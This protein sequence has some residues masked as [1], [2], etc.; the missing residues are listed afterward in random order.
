VFFVAASAL[1][2]LTAAPAA[3]DDAFQAFWSAPDPQAAGKAADAIVK[4]GVGFDEAY[5]RLKQGRKYSTDVPRGVVRLSHHFAQGEF[6]YTIEVPQTYD[7]A[8]AYQVRV[9]LHGGVMGREDGTIRGA[10]AIGALAGAEQ[11]YVLPTSWRDAPWWNDVQIENLDAILDSLRRAYNVDENRTVLAGVSDG[12]TANYYFAMRDTTPFASFNTLN[13]AMAVLQSPELAIKV[14]L[15]PQNLVNKPFFIVNGGRDPLY[16]TSFVEPYIDHLKQNGVELVYHPQPTGV[17]NTAWWP[18]EKDAFETFVREHPRRPVPDRLSWETDLSG[19]SNRA[20]WLVIDKLMEKDDPRE[21]L[22]DAN[23][24]VERA[25]GEFGARVEGMQIKGVRS[26]SDADFFGLKAGDVVVSIN[27]KTR[28]ATGDFLDWLDTFEPRTELTIGVTRS[29]EALDLKALFLPIEPLPPL[30]LF[31]FRRQAGRVDLLREGN[32]VKATTRGVTE[33][34]L[35]IS[36]DTFD[37]AKPITVTA[38]GKKVFD[39]R[40]KPSLQT[41]MKWAAHDNDRTMLFGA[42]IDVKLPSR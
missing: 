17:H 39:G 4:T 37:L 31:P 10:G 38:D 12:A 15:F 34:R 2:S 14:G 18:E 3:I 40:V 1:A 21:P 23:I 16:P 7:P 9:Q 30:P 35:L 25:Q 42:E 29:G 41:L 22:P 24:F 11:I 5:G 13:G 36:P 20:H 26:D 8:R 28:P 33:F 27:G 32:T 19:S 6:P